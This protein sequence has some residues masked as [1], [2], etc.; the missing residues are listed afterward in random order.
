MRANRPGP[1]RRNRATSLNALG[2]L[3]TYPGSWIS[4]RR[5]QIDIAEIAATIWHLRC[6]H[7][8]MAV[9]A[10]RFLARNMFYRLI[11]H[12]MDRISKFKVHKAASYPVR[13]L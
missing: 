1:M 10:D 4:D 12:I 13:L 6:L 11:S 2:G 8:G 3:P 5:R 9:A 7:A